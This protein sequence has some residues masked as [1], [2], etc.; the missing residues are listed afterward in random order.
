M[1]FPLFTKAV[2]SCSPFA[3]LELLS[4]NILTVSAIPKEVS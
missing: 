4:P 3:S 1:N 2:F